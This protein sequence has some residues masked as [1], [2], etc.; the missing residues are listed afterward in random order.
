MKTV[1]ITGA[2][3]GIGLELAKAYAADGFKVIGV[4]RQATDELSALSNV[5]VIAGIDV[6]DTGCLGALKETMAGRSIDILVNNA[7]FLQRTSFDAIE[8]ELESYRQQFE[9]NTLAPLRVTS[10][11]RDCLA[12]G[13]KVIIITSRM[14]SITD[15]TSGGH[16]AY[17]ISKSGVNSAGQ[18]LA[19]ELSPSGI[20]LALLH[21]G[22]VRT[23]MTGHTGHIEPS[24]S[25]ALLKARID[26]LTL[27]ST[28][29]FRHANG[30]QLPW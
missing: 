15:N 1:L 11:L 25:A 12:A 4:C 2:N 5:E 10:A 19:H 9:I 30:E 14:G 7:G 29:V 28:G 20:S 18:S 3:R 13:S 8:D 23:D 16:F 17:R 24:E 27:A 21:P 22:Y 26:E 6:T